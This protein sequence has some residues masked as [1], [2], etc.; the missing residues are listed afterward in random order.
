MSEHGWFVPGRG[1]KIKI[2]DFCGKRIRKPVRCADCPYHHPEFKYR[3][4]LFVRCPFDKTMITIRQH[5][6]R[7]TMKGKED[8][9]DWEEQLTERRK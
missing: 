5:K 6:Y 2:G 8:A 3:T 7:H 1:Q 9:E 4:C